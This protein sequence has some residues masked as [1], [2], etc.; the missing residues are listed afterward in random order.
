MKILENIKDKL[1]KEF[2]FIEGNEGF[3]IMLFAILGICVSY[4]ILYLKY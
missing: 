1:Y 2:P 4:L 3:M